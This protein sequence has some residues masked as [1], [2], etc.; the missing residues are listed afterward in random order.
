[1]KKHIDRAVKYITCLNLD[2]IGSAKIF[3]QEKLFDGEKEKV[4]ILGA[5][6][7]RTLLGM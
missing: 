1:M 7:D 3:E 2:I 5:L 4:E 6:V